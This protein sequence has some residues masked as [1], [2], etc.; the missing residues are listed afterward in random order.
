MDT[1][2]LAQNIFCRQSDGQAEIQFLELAVMKSS[3]FWGGTPRSSGERY[4][5]FGGIYS[6][7]VQNGK[8][9]L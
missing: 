8:A 3:M 4:Q 5:R 9:K 6:L 1:I 2:D 7:H